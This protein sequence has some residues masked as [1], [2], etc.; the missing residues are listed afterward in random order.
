M[1]YGFFIFCG[2][3]IYW[4]MRYG[5]DGILHQTMAESLITSWVGM[6]AI[7]VLSRSDLR[8]FADIILALKTGSSV[9]RK[10][11]STEETTELSA[12]TPEKEGDPD[13]SP[14]LDKN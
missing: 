10:S 5:R 11:V 6:F 4:I 8:V 13:D 1:A 14:R 2:Y 7:F 9:S 12:P 3:C